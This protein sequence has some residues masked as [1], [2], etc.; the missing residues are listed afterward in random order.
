MQDTGNTTHLIRSQVWSTQIK[1]IF[2]AELFAMKYVDMLSDFPD[3]DTINIPSI[4]QAEAY[5]Y[6]EGQSI[7]YTPMDTGNFTFSITEY[8][9]A[10]TYIT[11]KLRQDSFQSQFLTSQFV[12]KQARAIAVAMEVHALRIGP[13][14]QTAANANSINGANHR[15]IASGTNE[16]IDVTDFAKAKFSLQKANVPMTNLIAIV[17]PSVEYKLKTLTNIV[18]L[19]NNKAWEGIVRDDLST[20]MKFSFNIFGWDVYVSQFLKT[21][22]NET[23]GTKTSAA[24]VANLFFS[25]TPDSNPFIGNVRQAPKVESD[26]NKD[27]QREEYVT[28]ARWGMALFRPESLV[29]VISDTDQVTF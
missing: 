6:A 2:D 18:A 11:N 29:T 20:G 15:F 7:R 27:M 28:T 24:G 26:Y 14:T 10:G 16:T 17:D 25:A 1:D 12:P 5:D 8:K 21:G 19:D 9:A 13:D 22:V 3:G 23:I 4:G